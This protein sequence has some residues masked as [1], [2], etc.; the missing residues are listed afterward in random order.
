MVRNSQ[1]DWV[2]SME[3]DATE[4]CGDIANPLTVGC[5][6][7][8]ASAW[9]G[10]AFRWIEHVEPGGVWDHKGVLDER[11]GLGGDPDDP[12]DDDY[13]YPVP[14]S[15]YEVYYDIWSKIH[16]GFVGTAAG[17]PATQLQV[18][19]VVGGRTHPTDF[20]SVQVGID[21][22]NSHGPDLTR[23]QIHQAVLG[24][25]HLWAETQDQD[26]RIVVPWRR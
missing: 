21:L 7:D 25:L 2:V 16:Y 8:R 3:Q 22:Y 6:L 18:G 17:W 14:G 1:E 13:F 26:T 20:V 10:A 23:Y 11:L 15:R 12:L 19:Q 4:S 24:N 5:N 9:G